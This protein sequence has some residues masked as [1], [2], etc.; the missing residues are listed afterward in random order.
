MVFVETNKF[1]FVYKLSLCRTVGVKRQSDFGWFKSARFE[2]QVDSSESEWK[3]DQRSRYATAIGKFSRLLRKAE[4]YLSP[5]EI[6]NAKS[7]R[8]PERVQEPEESGSVQ[9]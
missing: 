7:F 1:S 4:I 9:Q 2:P 3:Q 5:S 8:I 6:T